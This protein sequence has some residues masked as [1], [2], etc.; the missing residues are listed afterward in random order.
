M[1][2]KPTDKELEILRLL[3][4]NGPSTVREVNDQRNEGKEVGYTTTLKFMQ[5]MFEKG[6]VSREKQGKTHIY[7]AEATKENTQ[8]QL[9]NKLL[10]TAFDGSAMKLVM[11]ALG[12]RKSSKKRIGRNKKVH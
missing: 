3:W 1:K 9:L 2:H 8:N 7:K 11:Q 6:L 5:I 4:K 10:D 12:N